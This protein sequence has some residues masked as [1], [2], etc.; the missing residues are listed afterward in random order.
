MRAFP[1]KG[2]VPQDASC[3]NTL[4]YTTLQVELVSLRI[5]VL[6]CALENEEAA[7]ASEIETKNNERN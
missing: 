5:L 3:R 4:A 7:D 2:K 1:K 6:Q